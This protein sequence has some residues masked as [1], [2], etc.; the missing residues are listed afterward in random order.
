MPFNEM[1]ENKEIV[2]NVVGNNVKDK[3]PIR[4]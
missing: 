2:E 3:I 1:V 4:N